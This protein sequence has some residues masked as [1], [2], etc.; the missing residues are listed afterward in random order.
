MRLG[1]GELSYLMNLSTPA[2][3]HSFATPSSAKAD[4]AIMGAVYPSCR[5]NRVLSSPSTSGIC[6]GC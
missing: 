2:S 1:A 5:I 3:M 4:S 6:I